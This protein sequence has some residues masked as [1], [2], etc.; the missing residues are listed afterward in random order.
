MIKLDVKP[1]CHN[2]DGFS[3]VANTEKLYTLANEPILRETTVR[4]EHARKCEAMYKH[5]LKESS[6]NAE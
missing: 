5:I 6:K 2:C 4:C 1:Y 3:P